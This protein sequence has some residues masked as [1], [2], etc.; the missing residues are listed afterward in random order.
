MHPLTVSLPRSG[1]YRIGSRQYPDGTLLSGR[2]RMP[3]C[4]TR[5][6]GVSL[7]LLALIGSVF[8]VLVETAL[9]RH[10]GVHRVI[11]P[12]T[13]VQVTIIVVTLAVSL[14][15]ARSRR[16]GS[17]LSA[18]LTPAPR[19]DFKY[20][21]ADTPSYRARPHAGH[22]SSRSPADRVECSVHRL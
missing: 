9:V 17:I 2:V 4:H 15:V 14:S 16:T 10:G 13:D 3:R 20:Y 22:Y 21:R 1:V 11:T 18:L 12:L 7:E 6:P 19:F 5:H 8:I